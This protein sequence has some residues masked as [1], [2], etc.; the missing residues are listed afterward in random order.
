M[1]P[2]EAKKIWSRFDFKAACLFTGYRHREEGLFRELERVGLG[3]AMP[4]WQFP[5]PMDRIF[6]RRIQ[7]GMR[8]RIGFFNS[9]MGHYRAIKTAYEMGAEH[10]LVIED[11][12]RFLKDMDLLAEIVSDIPAGYDVALLD[13]LKPMKTSI[14]EL[15]G[16]RSRN[17]VNKHWCRFWNLRS[18]ACYAMS[19]RAMAQWISLWEGAIRT[20]G[21]LRIADQYLRGDRMKDMKMCYAIPHAAIQAPAG[22]CN[23]GGDGCM[24][25]FYRDIGLDLNAYAI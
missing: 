7:G 10:C 4:L 16:A 14:A 22:R 20:G 8:Q 3:D 24:M 9:G 25:G 6:M 5:C 23:S 13:M 19:R 12:V 17:M 11:D 18:F 21:K 1:S 2:E 15:I